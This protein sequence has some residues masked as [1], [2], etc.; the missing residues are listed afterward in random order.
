LTAEELMFKKTAYSMAGF[1][2][3]VQIKKTPR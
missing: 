2:K 1:A 3:A